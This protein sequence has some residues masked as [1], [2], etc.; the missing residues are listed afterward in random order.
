MKITKRLLFA[1]ILAF[2]G[3]FSALAQ[4]NVPSTFKHITID[5]LFDDWTGVPLAYTAPAGPT[6]AIQY[7]NIYI[8]NDQ[9]NLYVRFT[10]YSP[11]PAAFQNSFDNVFI[12][13]DD[14]AS[15]GFNVAGIGSEMLIQWG[16]GYQETNG[17]FNSGAV[18]NLGWAIAGSPDSTD[19]EFSI[20]LGATYASDGTL[21]FTNSTI[22]LLLEGDNTSYVN[23]IF[24]P[25]SGGF[26]YTFASPPAELTTNLPLVTLE[27]SSWEVNASGTDLGTNW[28]DSAYDD[29]QPPWISG[30]GLFGYTPT[31]GVYPTINTPLTSSGQNTFYFRTHF[32]WNNLPDNLAF[33]ATNYLSDGAVYY[34]NG[35]EV[36]RIRM[37]A[38]TVTYATSATGTNVPPGHA[39]I[40]AVPGGVLQ[41]G[42]NI[43]EV[44]AH[45][46]PASSADM[47]FGLSLTAAAR[48][49]V[50]ILDTNQPANRLVVA[51]NSTTFSADYTGSGPLSFQWLSNSVAIPD[52]TNDTY[53]IPVVLSADAAAYALII[54][55]SLSTNTTRAAVLTVSNAPVV[56]SDPSQPSDQVL[57]EGQ[58]ATVAAVVAGSPPIQFQWYQGS[59]PIPG[60]TNASYTIPFLTA[61][62]AG[63][64]Y[65]N[66]SNPVGATNS[67]TATLT[68]L[69]S[70]VPPVITQIS[71]LSTQVVVTFSEPVDP[72]TA[73]DSAYYSIGGVSV[74]AAAVNPSNAAQVVLTTGS[75]LVFGTAYTLTVNGVKDV[76]DNVIRTAGT[77]ARTI[78]IDGSFADWQGM[79]PLYSGPSGT[80]GAADFEYI[81][82][83]DDPGNYYFRVTLWH[84]IPPTSGQFPAYVNMFFD[85]DNNIN[86]GYLPGTIGSE[87]LIQSGYSY[88]EKN[89][90]FNEGSINGLNWLSLPA[91]PGTNFEFSFSK[92]ATF[93]SDGTPVF[94]TNILNFVFQG[95]TPGFVVENVAPASGVISY[96]NATP[97][98]TGLQLGGLAVSGLSGGRLAVVWNSPGT[99]QMRASLV[100]GSWTNVPAAGSPYVLTNSGPQMFFRLAQ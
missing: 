56:F 11:R 95:M 45:Q 15:T 38:G 34:I 18:T 53:T 46:A 93:A 36:S 86:T 68:V 10:L 94:T 39:D 78:T 2:A 14:N 73:G 70:S 61:T 25:P 51:G 29:S 44:E 81:Y 84:D 12:D 80:D 32:S 50:T 52:A 69:S 35:A 9:T 85:T 72:T 17:A 43:L 63:A 21:A 60:A 71:A 79:T 57:V 24:A 30:D 88:Q 6:N 55:N 4:V 54:G 23:T 7:E 62:N 48:Y 49:P 28:L 1:S 66:V 77:F 92:A 96:T 22:A 97:V 20:S 13:A 26:V 31:P 75:G 90:G 58:S 33:V 19:F 98:S 82:V 59:S 41:I 83:Y 87:L 89:G 27:N 8:A 74:T 16:A 65:V 91:A 5:G 47:V 42:D 40:F 37:P 76:F 100:S 64:Y 99:L 67:R 3:G